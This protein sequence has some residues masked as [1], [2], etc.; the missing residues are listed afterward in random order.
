V[1]KCFKI[2]L[3]REIF[4]WII[5]IKLPKLK[6]IFSVLFIFV[7]SFSLFV[8]AGNIPEGKLRIHYVRPDP[9]KNKEIWTITGDEKEYTSPEL[10]DKEFSYNGKLGVE[11]SKEK[12][13]FKLW[14]PTASQVE[15]LF[16]SD[17][18]QIEANKKYN[19]KNEENIVLDPYAKSMTAFDSFEGKDKVGK[20]AGIGVI[21]D[22]VYNH[23]ASRRNYNLCELP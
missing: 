7:L 16:F 11:Y 8:Q 18:D 14:A 17:W 22:V 10:I 21:L 15:L 12:S 5:F 2:S 4:L 9:D 1:T 23:T 6:G 19:M 20:A 3:N 13:T